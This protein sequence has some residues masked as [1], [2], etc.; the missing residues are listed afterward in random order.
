MSRERK[1]VSCEM[2][3]RVGSQSLY[4]RWKRV[5]ESERASE[6][7]VDGFER[8]VCSWKCGHTVL[9]SLPPV[10]GGLWSFRWRQ[11]PLTVVTDGPVSILGVNNT[12]G[13]SSL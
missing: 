10:L 6:E 1:D 11:M 4:R 8:S 2:W 9:M 5:G 13:Y 3:M 12:K 7:E